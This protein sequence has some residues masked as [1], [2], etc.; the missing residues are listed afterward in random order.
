MANWTTVFVEVPGAMF[1][2]VKTVN[3]PLR[4]QHQPNA[5]RL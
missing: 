1:N 5:Q 3:D 2:P 4:A